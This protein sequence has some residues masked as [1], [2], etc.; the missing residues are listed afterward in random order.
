MAEHDIS[1][2]EDIGFDENGDMIVHIRWMQGTS[3]WEPIEYLS[4]DAWSMVYD[5]MEINEVDWKQA[6]VY[7]SQ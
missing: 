2:I 3:S 6:K 4:P 7:K 1:A 5:W